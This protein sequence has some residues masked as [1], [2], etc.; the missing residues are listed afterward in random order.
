MNNVE[1]FKNAEFGEI[2]T[3]VINGEPWFVAKDVTEALEYKNGRQAIA[4]NVDDEDKGVNSV[5]TL[6]GKQKL[7]VINESGLYSL[8]INSRLESAKRFKHWVTSD[9]LPAIRKTGGYVNNDELFVNTYLPFVDD[10]TKLLFTQTLKTVRKQNEI[11][12]NQNK[13]IKNQQFQLE[14]Q[15][16][17]VTYYDDVLKKKGL[18]NTSVIAK[19]LGLYAAKLNEI[20]HVNRILFKNGKNWCPYEEYKWLVID[21]Y[22]DYES[23]REEKYKPV[24]KWTE[25][26]R[27][28]IVD[29][30]IKWIEKYN[31]VSKK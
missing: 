2:R 18:I 25:K 7:T 17:K 12:E 6:G 14:E 27:K 5:D 26:G 21:G 8:V 29:N 9:I 13:Q 24:L 11:I 4:S 16:P 30:Y 31:S 19:D 15:E 10:T 23:Y 20:M 3:V 22:A 1:V 28:W